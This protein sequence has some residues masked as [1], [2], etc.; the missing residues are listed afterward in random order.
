MK[1]QKADLLADVVS[2]YDQTKTTIQGRA[3]VKTISGDQAI[4]PP[5]NKFIDVQTDAALTPVAQGLALSENGRVFIVSAEAAG[6]AQIA[7]YSINQTTLVHTYIGKIQ[8]QMP[9]TAA[10]TTTFRS[11]KVIDTGTTGW[12]IFITT[13]GSVL[14]NGGPLLLNKIDL[15]DF[16]PIG[17]PTINFAT[18]NDQKA[19]YFN[20]DPANTGTGHL[21]TASAGSV[22]DIAANR[23]YVHNGVAA[24]HQYY[25]FD[26]S[27]A[28]QYTTTAVSVS[29]ASPGVVTHTAHPFL[30]NDPVVFTAGTLPTGLVVG[31]T[32]FVRNPT[33]NTYELSA[34][35]GGA[36][37]NTT[38]SPSAGAFIGRAF[39]TSHTQF[40]HKTGNLPALTGTLLLTDSEYFAQP[41]HTTNAGFDCAFFAT[42]TQLY[43]GRLSELTNGTTSW[44]SLVTAN[45]LGTTNQITTPSML[46]AAWSNTL[47]HAIY[48]VAGPLFVMKQVVNNTITKI[49]GGNNNRYLE[50]VSTD[51]VEFQTAAITGMA[52]RLGFL[53]IS[54]TAT[55]GQ[56]GIYITDLRSNENFDYSYI[57]TKVLDLDADVLR[58]ITTTDKLFQYTGSLTVYYRTSGFGTIT[59]GWTLLPF[60][61]DISA[62]AHASQ[63]QFKITFDTLG[64]D[65]SIPS[66]LTEFFLGYDGANT[67]SPNWE[68]SQDDSS[69]GNPTDLVFRLKSAYPTSI[70]TLRF[71][72]RDLSNSIVTDHD[73]VTDI[74][75]FSY[76]TN[77]GASYT[78]FG[79]P[80]N[81]VGT[82]VRYRYAT[83]PG[84]D[85]RP[86]L[87]EE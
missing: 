67:M 57:V 76:S 46:N 30:V 54:Q 35:S 48:S 69:S 83:P 5:L 9:D 60:S 37:I 16:V 64:L 68:Y 56:R 18:G 78:A 25:V 32:Y 82:L 47:D 4:G 15:A 53:A 17:F 62:Y 55:T 39:G 80:P 66:Q 36:S 87:R 26:V 81:T 42:N 3:T 38:G 61:E 73:S 22:L 23:L 2:S 79:T 31:T 44:P 86:S 65:T 51:V 34:T 7:L 43:L 45:A 10:T 1:V 41:Q 71:L 49:F 21:N 28:P 13:T 74:A 70:P 27:L 59:G 6:L 20:Q 19:V 11:I 33:A 75:R 40:L 58:F 52:S 8:F 77:D 85:I 84:V 14:I 50:G 29:V 72:A 12:K 63:I 24:T